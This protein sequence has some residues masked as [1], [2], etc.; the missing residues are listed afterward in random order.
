MAITDQPV[1]RLKQYYVVRNHS[2]KEIGHWKKGSIIELDPDVAIPYV[3]AGIL[4]PL[5]SAIATGL[6]PPA[7]T[8][9]PSPTITPATLEETPVTEPTKKKTLIRSS[10][11]AAVTAKKEEAP[12]APEVVLTPSTAPE[13]APA[14][15]LTPQ[16]EAIKA[17]IAALKKSKS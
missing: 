15:N 13:P 12:P 14:P 11:K 9:A 8:V 16:E 3:G 4:V 2:E 17:K 6:I 5:A 1:S 10:L 7:T